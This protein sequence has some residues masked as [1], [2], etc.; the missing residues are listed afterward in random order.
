L[1][2]HLTIDDAAERVFALA[3]EAGQCG[4]VPVGSIILQFDVATDVPAQMEAFFESD[5]VALTLIGHGRNRIVER[6]DPTA[7]AEMN[8]IRDASAAVGSERLPSSL[9]VTML[10]PCLM[11]TGAAILSRVDGVVFFAPA[12][13]GI[14][15]TQTLAWNGEGTRLNHTPALHH[16][17]RFETRAA[18]LLREFFK[19]RR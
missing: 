18:T 6:K 17:T 14:G 5:P 3:E 11:C 13:T 15:M 8:A 4:E 12:L 16:A 10:E 2:R 19:L 9:L 1:T 7:H